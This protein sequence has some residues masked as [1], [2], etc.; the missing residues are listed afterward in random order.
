MIPFQAVGLGVGDNP[1]FEI[2]IVLLLNISGKIGKVFLSMA[3]RP[4]FPMDSV[5]YPESASAEVY[6]K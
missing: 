2:D 6:L 3:F 4:L 5:F 1:A